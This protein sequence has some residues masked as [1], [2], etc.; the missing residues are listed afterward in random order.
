MRSSIRLEDS[1][2]DQKFSDL[3]DLVLY[4]FY[5]TLE[6][7][8]MDKFASELLKALERHLSESLGQNQESVCVFYTCVIW[9]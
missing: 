3:G 2:E 1:S 5:K 6:D 8:C 7:I 4:W 9:L